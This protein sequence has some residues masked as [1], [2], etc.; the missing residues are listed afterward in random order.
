M[1]RGDAGPGEGHGQDDGPRSECLA[2]GKD[3]HVAGVHVE[4]N[5]LGRDKAGPVGHLRALVATLLELAVGCVVAWLADDPKFALWQSELGKGVDQISGAF[6]GA[7]RAEEQQDEG[8]GCD[9]EFR[10]GRGRC[11]LVRIDPLEIGRAS[12]RERV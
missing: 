12:C 10:A 6:V 5:L 4:L 9:A 1:P 3:D 7:D 11:D 8:L 2:V